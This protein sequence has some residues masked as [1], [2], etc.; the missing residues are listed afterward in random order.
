MKQLLGRLSAIAILL[1]AVYA[2]NGKKQSENG[3]NT[4]TVE[5]YKIEYAKGFRV[6]KYT[7]YT[8]VDVC[9]PWDSTRLLNT[10]ILIDK[11]KEI[12]TDLPKGTIIRTP[13]STAV[14][15]STIHCST[16]SELGSVN[17]VKAVCSPE[18]IN[19]EAIKDGVAKGTIL[20][21][22]MSTN[23][24]VE[25]IIEL[26][27]EVIFAEPVTGQTYGNIT[28][29][30][31]P[32]IETPDY[33][34]N[35]PLGRA[36]WIR[37]YALFTGKEEVADSLFAVTAT[38]YNK[39]KDLTTKATNCP[40]VLLDLRYMGK[41]NVAGGRS[42]MANLIADAGGEYKWADNNSSSFLPLSFESVFDKAEDADIWLI[43]NFT[44]QDMTYKSLE[45]EYKPYS[46]FKA[47]RDQN[48]WQCN[49][50]YATYYED[51]PIHPDWVLQD[52]GTIFHPE[53][54]KEYE[55]KYYKKM[56]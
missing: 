55:N 40:T 27:P 32:I 18:Y 4:V 37:F 9:D 49:T 14:A 8:K 30:G 50:S 54:F 10:Y 6:A 39:I 38:N 25:K 52:L 16:L 19:L 31:I 34:E 26:S 12:P 20:N 1:F 47:F 22:G 5:E 48:I 24:D 56:K 15:Y 21:V 7:D 51:I 36:E 43:K 13:L 44:P 23:P 28:K 2:C 33:M 42:F 53:L 45:K 11:T 3:E 41:W 17:I 29:T 46:Y 35:T